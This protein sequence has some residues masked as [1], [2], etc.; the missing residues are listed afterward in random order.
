MFDPQTAGAFE[1]LRALRR[2]ES[3]E[4]IPVFAVQ[5]KYAAGSGPGE[6]FEHA[7]A[8]PAGRPRVF[9]NARALEA[10][11]VAARELSSPKEPLGRVGCSSEPLRQLKWNCARQRLPQAGH[12]RS[13]AR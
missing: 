8:G 6:V 3:G 9:W 1:A 12:R 5:W 13:R 11:R 4:C 2:F 10:T 7:H